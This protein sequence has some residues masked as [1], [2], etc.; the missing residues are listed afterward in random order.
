MTP[1]AF[2][3]HWQGKSITERQG[4]QSHFIDL[5]DMLGMER[6]RDPDSY[7][8]ERGAKTADGQG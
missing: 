3:A 6:P 1:Q 8:F 4:A 2:I 5:C 7:C